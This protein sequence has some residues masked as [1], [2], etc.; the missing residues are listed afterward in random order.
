MHIRKQTNPFKKLDLVVHTQNHS[1]GI[2]KEVKGHMVTIEVVFPKQ[3]DGS[4]VEAKYSYKHLRLFMP[5]AQVV[6]GA[7]VI[8]HQQAMQKTWRYRIARWWHNLWRRK[9]APAAS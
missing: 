1:R 4:I 3:P 2:V 9:P 8:M 7:K 5:A 6:Q